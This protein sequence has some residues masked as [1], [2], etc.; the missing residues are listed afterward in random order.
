MKSYHLSRP[1]AWFL[2]VVKIIVTALAV[3][4]Y[5]SAVSHPTPLA[6]RLFLLA[7]LTVLGWIFYVQLPKMPT[8]IDVGQDGWVQFRGRRGNQEVHVASIRSI[9]RDLGGKTVRVRHGGGRLRMLN[10]VKDFYDFLAT[11]KR[12]NPA[13][14]IRGF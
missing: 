13:I 14:E 4:A 6:P 10:G 8:E 5:L 12:L 3:V 1:Y 2:T 9:G 11:V 7:A